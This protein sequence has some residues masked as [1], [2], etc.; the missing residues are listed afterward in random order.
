MVSLPVPPG[1]LQVNVKLVVATER[2]GRTDCRLVALAPLQPPDAV[3]LLALVEDQASVEGWPLATLSGLAVKRDG[4]RCR[5]AER[6]YLD[7]IDPGFA[8]DAA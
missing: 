7:G 8:A 2:A 5:A 1:P 6:L 4:G 3:Q